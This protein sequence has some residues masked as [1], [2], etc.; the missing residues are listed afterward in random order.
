LG[1]SLRAFLPALLPL[2]K[3][4]QHQLRVLGQLA[5]CG[6]LSLGANLFQCPP[7]GHRHWAP[8]SCGDRHCPGCQAAKSPQWL[9]K[10]LQSL[11][12][13]T[14]YHGVFTLPP[15]LNALVLANPRQLYPLLFDCAAQIA[16]LRACWHSDPT[17]SGAIWASAPCCIPGAKSSTSIP[18]CIAL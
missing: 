2:L 7:C 15:E 10:Q 4:G 1:G 12:P 18:I 16:P 13:V 6:T 11:L 3:L 9:D 5:A 8:R 17:G 14:Y